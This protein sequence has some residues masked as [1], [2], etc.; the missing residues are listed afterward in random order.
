MCDRGKSKGPT[1]INL[2]EAKIC[3][4][5]YNTCAL[6]VSN[7]LDSRV[8]GRTWSRG[9]H[10]DMDKNLSLSSQDLMA[11]KW[12]FFADYVTAHSFYQSSC[13]VP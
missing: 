13:F 7:K 5:F 6:K 10:S 2:N 8:H 4:F 11:K 3:H 12:G 1:E 9:R